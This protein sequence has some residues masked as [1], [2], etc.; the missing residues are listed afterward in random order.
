MAISACGN[1]GIVGTSNGRVDR[2]NLQSG[3]HRASYEHEGHTVRKAYPT[4]AAPLPSKPTPHTQRLSPH[5]DAHT[6][7]GAKNRTA[8]Q[9]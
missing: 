3:L 8:S 2:Y 5:T 4:L 9:Y 1:F 6:F 7:T